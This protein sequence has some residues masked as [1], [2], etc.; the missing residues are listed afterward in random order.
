MSLLCLQ[1]PR[2]PPLRSSASPLWFYRPVPKQRE[3]TA[4]SPLLLTDMMSGRW[5]DPCLSETN[6]P[7]RCAEER[8]HP[9]CPMWTHGVSVTSG[10]LA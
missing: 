2:R 4:Q 7:L 9:C 8:G 6:P 3:T 10:N 1:R 5:E